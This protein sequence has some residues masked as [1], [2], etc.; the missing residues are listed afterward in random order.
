MSERPGSPSLVT[1]P[2]D[3][4]SIPSEDELLR[5][6]SDDSPNMIAVDAVS[7]ARRPS[8][9]AFK[10][11]S[12]GVSVYRHSVLAAGG[13]T[14]A[15]VVVRPTNLVVGLSV[16]DVRAVGLGARND[17]WPPGVPDPT[18]PR[19]AA[20]ALIVGW[21]GLGTSERRRKQRKLCEAPSLRFIYP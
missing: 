9:G 1:E 16:A 2:G 14:P 17:A 18:H 21:D 12:D 15:D 4:P 10:P 8:S 5:R 19:H 20:H 11:D 7:G 6:L 3:D 13:C